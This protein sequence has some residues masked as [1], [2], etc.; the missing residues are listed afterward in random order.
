[1]LNLFHNLHVVFNV[2]VYVFVL[3]RALSVDWGWL[4]LPTRLQ[5]YCDLESLVDYF[6]HMFVCLV[7]MGVG[8]P[9]PPVHNDIVTPR[10]LLS[11]F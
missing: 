11:F 2:R 6:L 5:R 7:W 3:G 10:H 1:M 8:R 9:C 4:P